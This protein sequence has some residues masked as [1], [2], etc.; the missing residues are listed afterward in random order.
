MTQKLISTY[1]LTDTR[2]EVYTPYSDAVRTACRGMGGKWTNEAWVL[3]PARLK[4]VQDQ[5]G[6][7]LDDLVEV[8]V[9]TDDWTGDQQI[10]VGWYILAGRR[11]RDSRAEVHADLVAGMVPSRGGSMK[12]PSV[13]ASDDARFRLWVP[14]DFATDHDLHIV[15]DPKRGEEST[16]PAHPNK[17]E[18]VT[19]VKALMTEL[20]VTLTDL[21]QVNGHVPDVSVDWWDHPED[22]SRVKEDAS[23]GL[24][25]EE[26]TEEDG[27]IPF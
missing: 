18:A 27:H 8:E 19:Q 7:T 3:H 13:N 6:T 12:S 2:L 5:L 11:T 21:V 25:G 16:S 9:G 26:H 4:E 1:T 23:A 15:T 17:T 24:E 10:R 20:G 22:T 14:R